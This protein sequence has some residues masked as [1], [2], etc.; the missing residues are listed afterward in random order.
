MSTLEEKVSAAAKE[1]AWKAVDAMTRPF[2]DT[3]HRT[4]LAY[5]KDDNGVTVDSHMREIRN[6]L[7]TA[8]TARITDKM[9]DCLVAQA[10]ITI[11]PPAKT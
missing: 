11:E 3:Y 7:F 9:H 8:I 1:E 4:S 2:T 5:A 10:K 6:A